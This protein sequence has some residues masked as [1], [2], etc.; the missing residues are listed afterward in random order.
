MK[1]VEKYI[2]HENPS[3]TS[4]T[5][6]HGRSLGRECDD[7]NPSLS[8]Y[9]RRED[10]HHAPIY[11]HPQH[12]TS[13]PLRVVVLPFHSGGGGGRSLRITYEGNAHPGCGWVEHLD[14]RAFFFTPWGPLSLLL[15]FPPSP[16]PRH[17]AAPPRR[18]GPGTDK[19]RG[20]DMRQGGGSS[21]VGSGVGVGVGKLT[22][23]GAR[24]SAYSE[25]GGAGR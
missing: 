5:E 6:C 3:R 8:D 16:A 17:P 21:G 25:C 19:T 2:C 12:M 13:V 1:P 9:L 15:P 23:D 7:E 14:G 20:R 24:G 22:A 11:T 18:E 4:M 10:P